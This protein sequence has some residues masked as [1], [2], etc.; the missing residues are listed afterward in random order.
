MEN[1]N[2]AH[3]GSGLE[4]RNPDG[5]A[6]PSQYAF[7]QLAIVP[8]GAALVFVSGQG[9]GKI[10]GAYPTDFAV[11]VDLVF[12]NV[13]AMLN[14]AGSSLNDVARITVLVVDHDQQRHEILTKALR[15]TFSEDRYPASTLI[16]VPRLA[17]EGMLIEIDAV[18]VVSQHINQ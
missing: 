8:A 17:S 16:P 15:A 6:D 10:D 7:S 3:S 2:T 13:A 5:L 11:Q 14:A 1:N 9:S 4:L 18:G 12:K